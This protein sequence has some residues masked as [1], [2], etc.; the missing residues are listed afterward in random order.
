MFNT[1]RMAVLNLVEEHRENEVTSQTSIKHNGIYMLYVDNFDDDR[2]VPFYIGQSVNLQERYKQHYT[3][4][5]ALN[6]FRYDVYRGNMMRESLYSGISSYYEGHFKTCKIFKYMV[7]HGC[8][9]ADFHMIAIEENID[10]TLI[11]LEELEQEYFEKYLPA[12]FG[13]NQMNTTAEMRKGFA[14]EKQYAYM[15]SDGKNLEK[16]IEYGYSFFNYLH[17]FPKSIQEEYPTELN[18]VIQK[19]WKYYDKE[20]AV[21]LRAKY[22]NMIE[23]HNMLKEMQRE[24]ASKIKQMLKEDLEKYFAV[25]SLKSQD[26]FKMI[27]EQLSKE[28]PNLEEVEKYLQ[29]YSKDGGAGLFKI[30]ETKEGKLAKLRRR[31]KEVQDISVEAENTYFEH[32]YAEQKRQYDMIFPQTEY[33]AYPLKANYT[34]FEFPEI[35]AKRSLENEAG[36][37]QICIDYTMDRPKIEYGVYTDFLRIAYRYSQGNKTVKSAEYMIANGL[38]DV[39]KNGEENFYIEHKPQYS[40]YK[41]PFNPI[42]IG[43]DTMITPNMEYKTGINEYVIENTKVATMVDVINEIEEYISEDTEIILYSCTEGIRGKILEI[44]YIKGVQEDSVLITKLLKI[45]KSRR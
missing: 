1:I 11:D 5:L 25:N 37:C 19:L 26:K 31:L 42:I 33:F 43:C 29:R 17:A 39:I 3:E 21:I 32:K 41:R 36:V 28:T 10:T 20:D 40:I 24:T 2:V 38:Q 18:E 13:F 30:L 4:L 6:R 9:L 44:E 12:F 34:P 22:G 45:A 7:E 23:K 15:I 16:Y 27:L 8:S 14:D 35:Y